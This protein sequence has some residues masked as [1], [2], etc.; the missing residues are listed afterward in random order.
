MAFV[1]VAPQTIPEPESEISTSLLLRTKVE[2]LPTVFEPHHIV[3]LEYPVSCLAVDEEPVFL[4]I[5]DARSRYEPL[6]LIPDDA[7]IHHSSRDN[8]PETSFFSI[9]KTDGEAEVPFVESDDLLSDMALLIGRIGRTYLGVV[10]FVRDSD[11]DKNVMI[12]FCRTTYQSKTGGSRYTSSTHYIMN[13]D[14]FEE[15]AGKRSNAWLVNLH[16]LLYREN[17]M[18]VRHVSLRAAMLERCDWST[19]WK[20]SRQIK[21][22]EVISEM[23]PDVDTSSLEETDCLCGQTFDDDE[24]KPKVLICGGNAKHVL[25]KESL[26]EWCKTCGPLKATCPHCRTAIFT[27]QADIDFLAYGAL[28]HGVYTFDKR[29]NAFENF[30]RSCADLDKRHA[31]N[32]DEPTEVNA[33]ILWN[34]WEVLIEGAKLEQPSSS[35]LNLQSARCPEVKIVN[36]AI[37]IILR[38]LDGLIK[39]TKHLFVIIVNSL[40]RRFVVEFVNNK[41]D[42]FLSARDARH[43]TENIRGSRDLKLRPGLIEFC[44]RNISRM[45]IF[46]RSR[47][48]QCRHVPDRWTHKHGIRHYI[49]PS[50]LDKNK[51][52]KAKDHSAWTSLGPV[53]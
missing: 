45:L 47:Q 51:K 23:F 31:S 3:K 14:E 49:S 39:P 10:T 17:D 22:H 46:Q 37:K 53:R 44:E 36:H 38:E 32:I 42:R 8:F 24:H 52:R 27:N 7:V 29:Y 6:P 50:S 28:S 35:P 43:L 9:V 18:A 1:N 34:A 40:Y 48:C 25:C 19:N 26:L 15:A 4:P 21:Y 20:A 30:E 13:L 2:Q 41:L 5:L 12:R 33:T 11:P 16:N